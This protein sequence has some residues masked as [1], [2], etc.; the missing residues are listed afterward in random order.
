M[1]YLYC[2]VD[3]KGHENRIIAQQDYYRQQGESV[4]IVR[5]LLKG[6]PWK[7]DKCNARLKRGDAATLVSAIPRFIAEGM[8]SYDFAY[9][10]RYFD[11]KRAEVKV[12]G[13]RWPGIGDD[14]KLGRR[15]DSPA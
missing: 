11:M 15:S 13:A 2:A 8:D 7:C 3:G 12:Y 1:P 4:L 14:A 5:G 10:K 9:E 6:G